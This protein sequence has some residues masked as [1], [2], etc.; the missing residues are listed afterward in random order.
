[1]SFRKHTFLPLDDYLYAMQTTIPALTRCSLHR[2]LES[3]ESAA[4]PKWK[5]PAKRKKFDSYP[6]GF[7]HIDLAEVRTAEGRLYLFDFIGAYNFARRLKTVKGGLHT[8]TSAHAGKKINRLTLDQPIKC[9][10]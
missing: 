1:V 7:F 6:I 8:N 10:D 9:R 5:G 2:C 4:R 3:R